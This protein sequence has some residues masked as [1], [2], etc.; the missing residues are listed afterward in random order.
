V[1]YYNLHIL[2]YIAIIIFLRFSDIKIDISLD[3]ISL[4]KPIITKENNFSYLFIALITIMFSSAVVAQVSNHIADNIFLA[5]IVSM[6]IVSIKSLRLKMPIKI[7]IGIYTLGAILHTTTT[8]KFAPYMILATLLIFFIT[9]YISAYKQILFEGIIDRNKL[10]GSVTLYLLL[11][12][13]WTMVYL[14]IILIDP[15]A[16]SG[17]EV[18]NWQQGFARVGYYSFVTLTTLGYGDILPHNHIAEFFVSLE[19]IAGIFYVAIVVS[20]LIS[21]KLNNTK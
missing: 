6:L 16:F 1:L 5:L 9:A 19:A 3:I 21:L 20:S 12:N 15:N 14:I 13:I 8:Y 4:M 11:G 18:T 10:I 17:L 7:L 2:N